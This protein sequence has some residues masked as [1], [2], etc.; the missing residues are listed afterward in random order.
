MRNACVCESGGGA[1]ECEHLAMAAMSK[2]GLC[3]ASSS[4]V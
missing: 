1:F 2:E 4:I 3:N